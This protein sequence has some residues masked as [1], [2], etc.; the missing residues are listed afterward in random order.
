M[1]GIK[2]KK[3]GTKVLSEFEQDF[4]RK[5]HKEMTIDEFCDLFNKPYLVISNY[6]A[7]EGIERKKMV[8]DSWKNKRQSEQK[9]GIDRSAFTNYSNK[10]FV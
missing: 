1:P 4:I 8:P 7:R 6:M 9:Q 10:Q 3:Y 2:G 5:H